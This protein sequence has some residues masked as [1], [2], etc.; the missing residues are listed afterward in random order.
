MQQAA[1]LGEEQ[2]RILAAKLETFYE[3]LSPEEQAHLNVALS[4]IADDEVDVTGHGLIE[5]STYL[6]MLLHV[7]LSS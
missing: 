3:G 5:Y 2:A 4:R 7:I 1:T 6:I